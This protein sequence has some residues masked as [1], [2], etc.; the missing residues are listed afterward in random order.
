L[1]NNGAALATDT[2]NKTGPAVKPLLVNASPAPF[3]DNL[4]SLSKG[5]LVALL[6]RAQ[7]DPA[8]DAGLSN[9]ASCPG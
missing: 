1:D 6:R 2:L 8:K 7:G 4:D 9:H 3:V 5:E